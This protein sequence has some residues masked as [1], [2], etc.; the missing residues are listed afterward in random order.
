MS[1]KNWCTTESRAI[2]PLPNYFFFISESHAWTGPIHQHYF[3]GSKTWPPVEL[4]EGCFSRWALY[5]SIGCLDSIKYFHTS[6]NHAKSDLYFNDLRSSFERFITIKRS[7]TCRYKLHLMVEF[8]SK[9]HHEWG[10]E[11][12]WLFLRTTKWMWYRHT[13]R[14]LLSSSRLSLHQSALE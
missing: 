12:R 5:F 3:A 11:N 2:S 13:S 10:T 9:T 7:S 4:A 8:G 6:I 14:R 1:W